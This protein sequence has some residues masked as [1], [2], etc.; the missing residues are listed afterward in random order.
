MR[1]LPHSSCFVLSLLSSLVFFLSYFSLSVCLD[2]SPSSPALRV[3]LCIHCLHPFFLLPLLSVSSPPPSSLSN[4]LLCL[5]LLLSVFHLPYEE[6]IPQDG[7][8]HWISKMAAQGH[9]G[10]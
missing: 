7:T 3:V 1:L 8:K 6:Y 5:L 10:G 4:S 9:P 2:L